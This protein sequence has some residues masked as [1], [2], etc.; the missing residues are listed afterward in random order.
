M[1]SLKGCF[2]FKMDQEKYNLNWINYSDHLREMLHK[3]RKTNSLSDVTLVCDD[4]IQFKAHKIVLS[5][6]SPVF[7]NMINE[8]PEN[9]LVIYLRG[10]QH[11]EMESILEFMYLGV[12]TLYQ[13]R[14]NEFL[15]VAQNLEIKEICKDVK[16]NEEILRNEI[17]RSDPIDYF[18]Y[19]YDCIKDEDDKYAC[20]QCNVISNTT[21]RLI[22]KDI[23][24]QN[25]KV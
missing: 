3:M 2:I 14:M 23:F 4:K 8:L 18:K 25:I 21:R 9:S 22:L 5:A 24:N 15:K 11:I 10:I 1:I 13:E 19:K 6:C 20:N 17:F 16:F 7:K 12:A